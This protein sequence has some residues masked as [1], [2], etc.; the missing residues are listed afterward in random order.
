MKTILNKITREEYL[1]AKEIIQKQ[2]RIIKLYENQQAN[3]KYN[4]LYFCD[5]SLRNG[6]YKAYKARNTKE[7]CEK[8]INFIENILPKRN[9]LFSQLDYEVK[10]GDKF[11]DISEIE[12]VKNY[13]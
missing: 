7:A 6:E 13:L 1:L 11:I 5:D 9:K 4:F 8:I 12:C 2:K 3:G 10:L